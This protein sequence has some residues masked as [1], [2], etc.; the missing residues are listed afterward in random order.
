MSVCAGTDFFVSDEIDPPNPEMTT[1]PPQKRSKSAKKGRT[2]SKKTTNATANSS[3]TLH[4]FLP[5]SA[6]GGME[7][8]LASRVLHFLT[9]FAAH[10][11]SDLHAEPPF[12]LTSAEDVSRA[13]RTVSQEVHLV[14]GEYEK[15][16]VSLRVTFPPTG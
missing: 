9:V 3:K 2:S 16:A 8:G 7:E 5:G 4:T 13:A 1:E 15:M 6:S 11:P 12:S 10:F 14:D